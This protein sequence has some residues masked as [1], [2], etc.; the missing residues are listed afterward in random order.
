MTVTIHVNTKP[1]WAQRREGELCSLSLCVHLERMAAAEATRI[2]RLRDVI[3]TATDEDGETLA[4]IWAAGEPSY[5][6]LGG[7]V[8]AR[9][10]AP[11]E[12]GR[13]IAS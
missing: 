11:A 10:W 13:A 7:E 4:C 9:P 3:V 2:G 6:R 12:T 5:W 1:N 8:V